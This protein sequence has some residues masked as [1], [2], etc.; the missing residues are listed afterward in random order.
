MALH[1]VD[2]VSNVHG[3]FR[4]DDAHRYGRIGQV[5]IGQVVLGQVV[6]GDARVYGRVYVGT[7]GR[8]IQYAEP[9]LA[10]R[11]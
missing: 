3:V 4:S 8:G 7:N 1:L 5:V 9:V 2:K 10:T 6:I 11:R